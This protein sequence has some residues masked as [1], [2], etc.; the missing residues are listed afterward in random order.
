MPEPIENL[1]KIRLEKLEKIK[2]LGIDPYPARCQRK[3]TIAQALK[4]MGKDVAVVG[5]IMA[6]RGHGRIQFFDLRD[7]SGKIQLVFK[8]DHLPPTT[9][10]LLPL[11]DIG[12]FIDAQGK[13]F[14]TQ[15]GET[16][17]LVNA[18]K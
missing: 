2:K 14:K 6:I 18:Q 8:K 12:D 17:V 7:E 13:V 16:S 15:A 10:N 4:M 9:Y 1:R 5:R 11:L 3:Q